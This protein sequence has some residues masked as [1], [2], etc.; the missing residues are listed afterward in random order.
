MYV[1]TG[2]EMH[3]ID[4]YT[5]DSIGLKEEVLMENAG[6]AFCR[7]LMSQLNKE[8]RIVVLIGTGNNGGDGFVIGRI[9]K[10]AGCNVDV[11]VIPPEGKIRG[12]ALVHKNIYECSGHQWKSYQELFSNMKL[13]LLLDTYSIVIDALLGTGVKGDP[14]PPYD[15]LIEKINQAKGKVI[16]VDIPSGVSGE[17]GEGSDVSVKADETYTFQAAKLSA[18]LYPTAENYGKMHVLDIG[19][20]KIAFTELKIKRKL[21]LEEQVKRTLVKRMPDAHKGSVGKAL[22]IGGSLQMIGAPVLTTEACLR[23]GAGLTTLAVPDIIHPIVSQKT[24]EATFLPLVSEGG[25]IAASSLSGMKPLHK[26]DAIAIGP[27][28]GRNQDYHLHD[29]FKDY[30]GALVMDADGLFHLAKELDKWKKF[31]RQDGVTIITPH[32]GE[33]SQLTGTTVREVEKNRY[34]ISRDFAKAYGMYV[35]LKGPYTIVTSPSGD[36]WVNTSGNASLA[37]GGSGDVLTGIIV[38][39]LLQHEDALTAVSN[40]VYIHGKTADKLV[41]TQDLISVTATDLAK[42]LPQVLHSLRYR[43]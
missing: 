29:I 25:E 15:H 7:Q 28:M 6:Q 24:T 42:R 8:E 11:W 17:G 4:R 20:P 41:E 27:G 16:S 34:Q 26:F 19:I 43:T 33:M 37:K 23:S 2:E 3:Q 35:V 38:A 10:E 14:R 13:D 9:L 36:Q 32:P 39:F 1:V 31:P 30:E 18:F 40:A 12:K 22:V 5:M 21:I